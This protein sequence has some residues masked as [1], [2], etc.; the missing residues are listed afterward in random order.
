MSSHLRFDLERD[1]LA[2]RFGGGLPRPAVGV[3]VGPAG[4]GKSVLLQR[5]THG[6][7]RHG[8][9][10]AYVSTELGTRNFLEQMRSLG[11][12]V[13]DALIHGTLALH[14]THPAW[15]RPHPR[16]DHL[17]RL[18]ASQVPKD[19]D[20]VIVDRLSSLMRDARVHGPH[21]LDRALEGFLR[22]ARGGRLVL[23]ALDPE[24]IGPAEISALERVSNLY[25]E[26]RSQMVGPQCLHVIQVR[27][28][29]RPLQRVA[30]VVVFRVEP[31]A[32]MLLE[33]KAVH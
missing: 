20:V 31:R 15:R 10:V 7:L 6:L 32:G 3:L 11:Y 9:R 13:E 22:W 18:L 8:S 25:L 19:R 24:D 2:Q 5:L 30:D 17:A 16:P 23:L 28:F 27:R 29:E 21:Q 14:T 4:A 12:P 1:E 33:I 26:Q